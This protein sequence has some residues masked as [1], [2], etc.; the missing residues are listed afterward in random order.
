MVG[1]LYHAG[2]PTPQVSTE[3]ETVHSIPGPFTKQAKKKED[4]EQP[5]INFLSY[6]TGPAFC[7]SC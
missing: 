5:V 6:I 2:L 3:S 7:M 1:Y 4:E